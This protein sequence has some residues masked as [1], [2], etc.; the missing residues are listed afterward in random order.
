[1]V[2]VPSSVLVMVLLRC[3]RA[4]SLIPPVAVGVLVELNPFASMLFVFPAVQTPISAIPLVRLP[5][6]VPKTVSNWKWLITFLLSAYSYITI[7]DC[8]A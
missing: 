1:M 3:L 8:H 7:G 2:S 5:S 6:V 4:K